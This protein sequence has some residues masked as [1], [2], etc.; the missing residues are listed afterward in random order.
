[1]LMAF[2]GIASIQE[3][4]LKQLRPQRLQSLGFF[5]VSISVVTKPRP[6]GMVAY[7]LGLFDLGLPGLI[8]LSKYRQIAGMSSA[9][10]R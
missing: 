10:Q 6:Y 9:R 8:G 5:C 1:M 3:N 4:A 2:G 7:Q